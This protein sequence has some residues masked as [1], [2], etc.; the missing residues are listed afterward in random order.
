[1]ARSQTRLCH[2]VLGRG[3]C[4]AA[5]IVG[6]VLVAAASGIS[7]AAQTGSVSGAA[8]A[9]SIRE[10][11]RQ[12]PVVVTADVLVV[13]DSSGAVAA[14]ATA[15]RAG[16]TAVL[17]AHRPYLGGNLCA[18]LRLWREPDET[19]TTPLGRRLFEQS[20]ARPMHIKRTLDQELIDAGVQFYFGC[21]ATDVLQDGAGHVA[22]IVIADRAGRQA[23]SAKVVIDA[24]DRATV[25]RLAGA[26]FSPYP[27]GPAE[28]RSQALRPPMNHLATYGK[29]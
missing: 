8:A 19:I 28:S 4:R 24:T 20:P 21:Y 18:T 15:A 9:T 10:S 23:I 1:M 27:S 7:A 13:G 22:G 5:G 26:K 2:R 16:A 25:A 17:V 11:A 3:A 29:C 12:I 14:A 6:A